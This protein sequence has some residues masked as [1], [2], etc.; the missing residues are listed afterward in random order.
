[1]YLKIFKHFAGEEQ[2]KYLKSLMHTERLE[3]ESIETRIE[4][5]YASSLKGRIVSPGF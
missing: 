1:M 5:F 2:F 4:A 3:T